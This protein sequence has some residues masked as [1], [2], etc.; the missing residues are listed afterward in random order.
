MI[1]IKERLQGAQLETDLMSFIRRK[2]CVPSVLVL[3][4]ILL[5]L[6][7]KKADSISG[8]VVLFVATYR[9]KHS[10]RT[11]GFQSRVPGPTTQA[12]PSVVPGMRYIWES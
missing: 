4:A 7:S 8:G 9:H 12:T 1:C 2:A 10:S 11:S 3:F 5:T 6:S